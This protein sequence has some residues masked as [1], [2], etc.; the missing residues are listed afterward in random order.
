MTPT[1][2][3][4]ALRAENQRLRARA[5]ELRFQLALIISWFASDRRAMQ[6]QSLGQY[7]AAGIQHIKEVTSD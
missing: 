7:R 3:L 5:G 2:K 6:Y 4:T 1:D